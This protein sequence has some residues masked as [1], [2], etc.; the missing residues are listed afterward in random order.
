MC[1]LPRLLLTIHLF[2]LFLTGCAEQRSHL[3]QVQED[4]VLHVLSRN[5]PTTY[6]IGA[7]GPAGVEYELA[8]GFADYLGVKLEIVLPLPDSDVLP[9]GQTQPYPAWPPGLAVTDARRREVR[10]SVPYLQVRQQLVYRHGS[11]RPEDMQSLNG[12]LGVVADGGHEELL[13]ELAGQHASLDG[14]P[15]RTETQRELLG[16]ISAGE[17]DYA[18]VD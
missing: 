1:P 12:S 7:D 16:V 11:D 4:G 2:L 13:S 9:H 5:S 17:L 8:A 10:F 14:P 15:I 3:E 6:Y 18:V